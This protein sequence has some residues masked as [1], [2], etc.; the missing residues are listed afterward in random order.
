MEKINN[1]G[2]TKEKTNQKKVEKIGIKNFL[3]ILILGTTGQIAWVM[4]NSNFNTFVYDEITKDPG[5]VA[6]MVAVSAVAATLTTIIMGIKSDKTVHKSGKRK[7]YIF[8]GYIL[9]GMITILFPM[10]SWISLV[11]VAVI[12]VVIMDAIMTFFGSTANDA[13]FNAW[14]TDISHSSNRNKIQTINSITAFLAIAI[15]YGITGVI[16]RE[17]SANFKGFG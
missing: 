5:P 13:A 15:T 1:P 2:K 10:V 14:I 17:I 11:G 3:A 7:P 6:W 9:W 8:Y 12:M 4:E 16:T